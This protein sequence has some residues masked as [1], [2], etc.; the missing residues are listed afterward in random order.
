MKLDKFVKRAGTKGVVF[1]DNHKNSWFYHDGCMMV[2]PPGTN[3]VATATDMPDW[4]GMDGYADDDAM[5][6]NAIL[7]YPDAKAKDIQRIYQGD[8]NYSVSITISQANY[9]LIESCDHVRIMY[10]ADDEKIGLAVF[11]GHNND[12]QMVA[13]I[14]DENY[15]KGVL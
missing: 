4:A 7:P 3:C 9:S 12:A 2:I 14:F 10:N 6:V 5:L 8:V 1:C 15:I 11:H 13:I